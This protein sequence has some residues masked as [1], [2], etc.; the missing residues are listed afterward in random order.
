[1]YQ[2]K[3]EEVD[4]A[5]CQ[6]LIEDQRILENAERQGRRNRGRRY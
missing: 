5:Y 6:K 1:M 3:A 4:Q 2:E